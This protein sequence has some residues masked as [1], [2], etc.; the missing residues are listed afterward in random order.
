M[1]FL[2]FI[3]KLTYLSQ[4]LSDLHNLGLKVQVRSYS[5]HNKRHIENLTK[6]FRFIADQRF[7]N[8]VLGYLLGRMIF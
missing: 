5:I 1:K 3:S 7:I 8:F 2:V 4:S 6:G